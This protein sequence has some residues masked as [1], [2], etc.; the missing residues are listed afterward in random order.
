[1]A[2]LQLESEE[3]IEDESLYWTNGTEETP[4]FIKALEDT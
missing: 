4:L 3:L 2:T 1:M